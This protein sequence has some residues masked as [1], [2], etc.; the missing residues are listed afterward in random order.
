[1]PIANSGHRNGL[2]EN[3]VSRCMACHAAISPGPSSLG[4]A[5]EICTGPPHDPLSATYKMLAAVRVA[6]AEIA[7]KAAT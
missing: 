1:M 4:R 2:A 7:R 5:I 6:R 3:A